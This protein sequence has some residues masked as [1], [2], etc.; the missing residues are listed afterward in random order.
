VISTSRPPD[1]SMCKGKAK[2]RHR[3]IIGKAWLCVLPK[4]M[5]R[6]CVENSSARNR[7]VLFAIWGHV[8]LTTAPSRPEKRRKGK[9]GMN[10]DGM[11]L[12]RFRKYDDL[13]EQSGRRRTRS[14]ARKGTTKETPTN[15]SCAGLCSRRSRRIEVRLGAVGDSVA[16]SLTLDRVD[17]TWRKP[18][19]ELEL[20]AMCDL[21]CGVAVC[22]R[23][24]RPYRPTP[25]KKTPIL[26]SAH[27]PLG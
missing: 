10:A 21:V 7:E 22:K 11:V 6:A 4:S 12:I 3:R 19:Y 13:G 23:I 27:A 16:S 26:G 5:N 20:R 17:P 1:L 25:L 24:S 9:A 18:Y 2:P 14:I 15:N 8:C